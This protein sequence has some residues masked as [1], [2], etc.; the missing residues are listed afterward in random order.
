MPL[1]RS[2]EIRKDWNCM[3]NISSWSMLMIL[4]GK[5]INTIKNKEALLEAN[6]GVGLEA[7][8]EKTKYMVI[9][10]P[11]CWTILQYTD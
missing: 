3:E 10:S 9:L 5:N 1:G 11:K 6:R 4:I 2:K 8:T 7:N